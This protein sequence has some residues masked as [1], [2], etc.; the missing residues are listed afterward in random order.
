MGFITLGTLDDLQ[1]QIPTK[2]TTGWADTLKD[3]LFQKI[4]DHDHS[5][6]GTGRKLGAGSIEDNVITD[7]NIRLRNDEFLRSRNAA[8]DG[9]I[10][11]LKVSGL[12]VIEF[13]ANI[14]RISL[15]PVNTDPASPVAGQL[16]VSDGTARPAGL[17]SYDGA[18]WLAAPNN[19]TA[20]NQGS[21]EGVFIQKTGDDLEFKT[22][23]AGAGVELTSTANE[24]IVASTRGIIATKPYT[25]GATQNIGYEET[26]VFVY[27]TDGSIGNVRLPDIS[28]APGQADAAD[29]VYTINNVQLTLAADIAVDDAQGNNVI[30][31]ISSGSQAQC[32]A[33]G[34]TWVF[35]LL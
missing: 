11:I 28:T 15:T 13:G 32:Y 18:S 27:S 25:L 3:E 16:Q 6:N 33:I 4:V 1:V 30:V 31:N 19:V 29:K 24:V 5:G 35:V 8:D 20:S 23:V 26:T 2:G 21:G 22:L 14:S 10:D 7:L 17:Y 34:S 9:D 12:D